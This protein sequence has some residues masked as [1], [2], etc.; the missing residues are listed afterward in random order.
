[1]NMPGFTHWF[2]CIDLRATEINSGFGEMTAGGS[3][4]VVRMLSTRKIN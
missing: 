1:M 3:D 4:S 2:K